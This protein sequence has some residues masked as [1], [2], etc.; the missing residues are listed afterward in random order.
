MAVAKYASNRNSFKLT[1]RDMEIVSALCS[2]DSEQAIARKLSMSKGALRSRLIDVFDKLGV[3]NRFELF[4]FAIHHGIVKS[5][6][7]KPTD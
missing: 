1:I 6:L 2:G 7:V 3:Q 5:S 4:V